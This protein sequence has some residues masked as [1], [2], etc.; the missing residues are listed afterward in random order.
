MTR[1]HPHR[2]PS[3]GI[4]A[5]NGEGWKSPRKKRTVKTEDNSEESRYSPP[6][7]GQ[8]TVKI[9]D[10]TP[11]NQQDAI[12]SSSNSRNP[13]FDLHNLSRESNSSSNAFIERGIGSEAHTTTLDFTT[14]MPVFLRSVSLIHRDW[15]NKSRVAN[16]HLTEVLLA[17]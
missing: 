7:A 10:I 6:T 16:L 5:V 15:R 9:I 1:E 8:P 12:P 11:I 14:D 2:V 17:E 4:K 3:L 13:V